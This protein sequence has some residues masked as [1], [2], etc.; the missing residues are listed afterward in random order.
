MQSYGNIIGVGRMQ[1]S[2]IPKDFHWVL[3][4]TF[5]YLYETYGEERFIEFLRR[6]AR[7]VYRPLIDEMK[8]E[9]LTALERHWNRIFSLEGGEFDLELKG[10][11]LMLE[12]KRCPAISFMR[13]NDLE[14]FERFCEHTRIVNEEICAKGGYSS[15]VEY[16]QERECCTQEFWKNEEGAK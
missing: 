12:V 6:V 14:V 1:E 8:T 13:E 7:E 9:G 3:S 16:D 10:D 15:T 4:H 2:I 5:K 11:R